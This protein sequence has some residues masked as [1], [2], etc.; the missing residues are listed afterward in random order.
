VTGHQLDVPREEN[1][2]SPRRGR[3]VVVGAVLLAAAISAHAWVPNVRGLGSLLDSAAPLGV[4]LVPALGIAA[5]VRR[6]RP[7]AVATLLPALTWAAM[8][9]SA[10]LST[11]TGGTAQLRVVSQNLRAGNPDSATT[12]R[13][14]V[15]TDPHLIGLQEVDV[16]S[17][18]T[19]SHALQNRYPYRATASTVSLWSRFPIRAYA[20]IDTGLAWTRAVRA[21]VAAPGGDV[22]VYVAHLGSARIGDTATRDRTVAAL[23]RQVRADAADRLILLGD[24]NTAATDRVMLPLTDL[25]RNAQAEAGRGFG[26]TWPA[27]LPV[28]RPDH[29]LYRGLTATSAGVL[30]TPG[31]DHRAVTAGFRP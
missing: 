14:L 11:G 30:R 4:A 27:T 2:G 9:G 22:V 25:L 10:W 31:S 21:V 26:F 20:G 5:L 3:L 19:V 7:A 18:E 28:T 29:V 12:V 6:S 8:F 1:L 23:A 13:A 17:R 24:L 16:R 15:A